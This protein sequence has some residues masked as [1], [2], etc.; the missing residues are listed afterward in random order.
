MSQSSPPLALRFAAATA[1]ALVCVLTPLGARAGSVAAQATGTVNISVQDGQ[2]SSLPADGRSHTVL[3]ISLSSGEPGGTGYEVKVSCSDGSAAPARAEDARFPLEVI[4]TAGTSVGDAVINVEVYFYPPGVVIIGGLEPGDASS[5]KKWSG[6]VTIELTKPG[7]PVGPPAEQ[8]AA[9][10]FSASLGCVPGLPEA[11]A[12]V[13]CTAKVDGAAEDEALTYQWFR[14]GEKV[15]ETKLPTYVWKSAEPGPHRISVLVIGAN[16]TTDAEAPVDVGEVVTLKV[17]LD[18]EPET[19]QVGQPVACVATVGGEREDEQPR[20]EWELDHTPVPGAEQS[21]WTWP[22]ASAG[23]HV[24]TVFVTTGDR[25]VSDE[26]NVLVAST[27]LTAAVSCVPGSPREGESV[28]CSAT[29]AGTYQG[30]EVEYGWYLDD[31]PMMITRTPFWTWPKAVI[32]QHTVSVLVMGDGRQ[33][34]FQAP[35][36]QVLPAAAP[37]EPQQGA[38]DRSGAT[39]RTSDAAVRNLEVALAGTGA[40]APTPAQAG[41]AGAAAAAVVLAWLANALRAGG[42]GELALRSWEGGAPTPS[43]EG[44]EHLAGG[45][46]GDL[47]LGGALDS[48]L[49]PHREPWNKL[50]EGR[51]TEAWKQWTKGL[52]NPAAGS[53]RA[54]VEKGTFYP[55]TDAL[56]KVTVQLIRGQGAPEAYARE[57]AKLM[58]A[59][60]RQSERITRIFVEAFRNFR[61]A[62]VGATTAE[63]SGAVVGTEYGVLD[64][65]AP[66]PINF[67][68]Q[69]VLT[70]QSP[71]TNAVNNWRKSQEWRRISPSLERDPTTV[72]QVNDLIA[73]AQAE[74]QRRQ[75]QL[76]NQQILIDK[77]AQA[78]SWKDEIGAL[79]QLKEQVADRNLILEFQRQMRRQA[80]R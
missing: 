16:H 65:R 38:D 43:A 26:H 61:A 51:I 70:Q 62:A 47:A 75:K 8:P 46:L 57:L 53:G 77:D 12:E 37:A 9:T 78:Q 67:V 19:P 17:V 29:V 80:R 30:E 73:K 23:P 6:D 69:V 20:Y 48:L 4:Y 10:E 58:H 54:V 63:S 35:P 64:N 68:E 45:L 1:L 13:V 39:G 2:P 15:D 31:S 76:G 5:A 71:Y 24:I 7:G 28:A 52:P 3:M 49:S 56:Q 14:D 27:E 72:K 21:A 60:S 41:V 55:T 79:Q 59:E 44:L 66:D 18:C 22:T 42:S 34:D 74:F 33:K 11:G 40:R 32:G 36:L 25:L 50:W